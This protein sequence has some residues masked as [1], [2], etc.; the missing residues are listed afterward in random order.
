MRPPES[1]QPSGVD[2]AGSG[3][4][5][6]V[7]VSAFAAIA[8]GVMFVLGGSEPEPGV[9]PVAPVEVAAD[10]PRSVEPL[11]SDAVVA[12]TPPQRAST[13]RESADPAW[14]VWPGDVE[15]PL[16]EPPGEGPLVVTVIDRGGRFVRGAQVRLAA[17][18]SPAI[19]PLRA[20]GVVEAAGTPTGADLL[21]VTDAHGRCRVR[22]VAGQ[23]LLATDQDQD[24]G[25]AAVGDE[26]ARNGRVEIFIKPGTGLHARVIGLDGK[27]VA[28]AVVTAVA[29]DSGR[30]FTGAADA[31]GTCLWR[32]DG[33]CRYDVTARDGERLAE[34]VRIAG[35]VGGVEEVRVRL[36]G[37][38]AID[39]RVLD[40]HGAPAAGASVRVTD[41]PRGRTGRGRGFEFSAACEP[42]GAFHLPLPG[43]GRY[44]VTAEHPD[45]ARSAL[46]DFEVMLGKPTQATLRLAVLG[47]FQGVVRW[48]DGPPIAGAALRFESKDQYGPYGSVEVATE[49]SSGADGTYRF[50]KASSE[51]TY[52]ASCVPDATRPFVRMTRPGLKP[53]PQHFVFDQAAT[54]GA[55]VD[56]AVSVDEG[57][58]PGEVVTRLRLLDERRVWS[59]GVDETLSVQGGRAP[60]ARLSPGATYTVDVRAPGFGHVRSESF[61]AG[62]DA[63]VAVRL[64]RAARLEV[65]VLDG[66]EQAAVGADVFLEDSLPQGLRQQMR[67]DARGRVAF[68]D[69]PPGTFRVHA[70]RLERRP[71]EVTVEL[72]AGKLTRVEM[73][74]WR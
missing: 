52:I 35:R 24:A 4:G 20:S 16:P 39:G 5:P 9:L 55:S 11:I 57:S 73:Q 30:S 62:R 70:R 68:A 66:R 43:P 60:L 31:K 41:N 18:V 36:L 49:A 15:E 23:T 27:G 59:S 28:G 71:L 22:A 40:P 44:W 21:G 25:I 38:A 13:A 50:A 10:G 48:K 47:E 58:A 46:G 12:T 65:R 53:T 34:T 8:L 32:L 54:V 61:V 29:I 33:D 2:R 42:D 17:P 14:P 45:W 7:I 6:Y 19:L 69:L 3:A 63:T 37:V 74:L 56:L 51:A 26:I 72:S 1:S 67:A 64:A